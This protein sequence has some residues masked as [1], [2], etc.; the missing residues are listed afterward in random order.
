MPE[1]TGDVTAEQLL[2]AASQYDAAIEAGDEP[3]VAIQPPEEDEYP[4]VE[5][6]E[7]ESEPEESPPEPEA[8]STDKEPESS[9]T[10]EEEAQA[11]SPKE[12]K[13]KYA[14]NRDRL[15]KT[16]ADANEVKEQNKRDR[17][18][19]EQAKTELEQQRQQIAATHGYR[20]EHG[21]T[22]KDYEEAAKG[23]RDEGESTLAEAADKKANE[24]SQKQDQAVTQNRQQQSAQVFEAKRQELMTQH[25]DLRKDDSEITKRANA[26]LRQHPAIARS[27]DGLQAAVNGA[28]MQ[29]D[30]EKGKNAST[31]LSELQDKYNK[32]EKKLSVTGGYTNEKLDGEKGFDDMDDTEQAQYLMRAATAHD[33]S[34]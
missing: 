19:V 8:D 12:K 1:E 2:A 7:A 14:K 15:N 26:L 10:E 9:L 32:L 30:A 18:A 5:E 29:I 4:A 33:N 20:D 34:L 17:E 16:W 23:F 3:S 11:P 24:L 6:T 13:S 27:P 28:L 31:E 22:A 21:H 25:P